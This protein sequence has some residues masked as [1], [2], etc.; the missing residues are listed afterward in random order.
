MRNIKQTLIWLKRF[1]YR[2]GYG[3]H[4]PFAFNFITN[5]IYEKTPYYAYRELENGKRPDHTSK[6]RENSHLKKVNRLL[7]RLINWAQPLTIIDSGCSQ[8]TS[9]YLRAAKKE[10]EY[11]A[12]ASMDTIGL[13]QERSIDFLYIDRPEDTAF[14]ESLFEY[15]V[16]RVRDRSMIVI[17]NIYHSTATKAF[18]KQVITDER[19]GITFD[20]YDLGILFFDKSKI[21]QHY[22]VNF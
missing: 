22:T 19:V 5:V 11:I 1:R 8:I 17:W 4:S 18:W 13:L 6:K 2:C 20:L 10:A 15:G 9:G 14:M 12:L 16:E 7:F 21:K 3:V